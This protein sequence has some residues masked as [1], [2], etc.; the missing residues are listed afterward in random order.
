M[1]E[2]VDL[3]TA[4]KLAGSHWT[5]A[6]EAKFRASASADGFITRAQYARHAHD[7]AARAGVSSSSCPIASA[8][9][10]PLRV[11]GGTFEGS[12]DTAALLR[13]I[14]GAAALR[15]MV[16]AF[17]ARAFANAHIDQ[18]IRSHNDPHG[19]RLGNWIAEKMT[20]EGTPWSDERRTRA[21]EEVRVAGGR[22]VVVHDRSSAHVAAWHSPK[23]PAAAVGRHFKL[24]DAR[25][26]MRLM[27]WTAREEGLFAASPRFAEWYVRFIGH[28][29]RIYESTA[30]Q[31]ARESARW[32][33]NPQNIADYEAAGNVMAGVAGLSHGAALR[34]LPAAERDDFDWPYER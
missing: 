28:F 25:I 24:D 20:G 19:D 13:E 2:K 9:R 18:F 3:P 15:Q 6:M 17:Y 4:R 7:E 16:N 22:T 8:P 11:L 5:S 10:V 14:G 12:N 30:P 26:W 32:S 23:R 21:R 1:P 27:F 33:E 34:Q 29:V 31:F